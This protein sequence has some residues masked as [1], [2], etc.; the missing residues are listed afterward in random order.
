MVITADILSQLLIIIIKL[1]IVG[2]AL[3][4]NQWL[5]VVVKRYAVLLVV[6]VV[7]LFNLNVIL[8]ISRNEN[9]KNFK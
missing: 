1:Q 8:I 4:A 2:N 3:D 7:A 9:S 6:L 5:V